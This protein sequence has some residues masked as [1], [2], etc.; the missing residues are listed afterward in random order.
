MLHQSLP[1]KPPA[2]PEKGNAPLMYIWPG[3]FLHG[4]SKAAFPTYGSLVTA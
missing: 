1:R 2:V 3:P 4:I